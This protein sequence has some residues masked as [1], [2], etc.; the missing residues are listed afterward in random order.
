[1]PPNNADTAAAIIPR[2]NRIA[3]N[4]HREEDDAAARGRYPRGQDELAAVLY[5][6]SKLFDA[7]FEAVNLIVWIVVPSWWCEGSSSM[8]SVLAK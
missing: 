3:P 6:G 5:L 2:S 8:F 4:E 7:R 1:M